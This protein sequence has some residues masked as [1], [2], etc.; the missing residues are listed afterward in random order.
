MPIVNSGGILAKR[1]A[2]TEKVNSDARDLQEHFSSREA[3][4]HP[5]PTWLELYALDSDV[6]G[7]VK[8]SV[9][10]HLASGCLRCKEAVDWARDNSDYLRDLP[11]IVEP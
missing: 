7:D 5:L 2:L 10:D 1:P 3:S 4:R 9:G 8:K 6:R 11:P